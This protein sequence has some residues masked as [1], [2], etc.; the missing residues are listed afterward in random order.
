MTKTKKSEKPI[1]PKKSKELCRGCED[2]FYNGNNQ[3]GV[4]E[5]CNYKPAKLKLC[6]VV[7]TWDTPP[8]EYQPIEWVLDCKRGYGRH[9]MYPHTRMY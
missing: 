9:Y 1:K 5:C 3:L 4:K 6:K 2:N 7:G 8:W